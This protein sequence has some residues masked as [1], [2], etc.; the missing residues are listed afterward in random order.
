MEMKEKI[1]VVLP[2][3]NERD[4]IEPL[5]EAIHTSI[6]N[7]DHEI[8]VVD[9]N[10]PD[11]TY[12]LIAS[13][14]YPY[15][16]PILRTVNRGLA[17]SIRYGLEHAEG[18]IF[19]IMDSDF[20]H[21]PKYLPFMLQA[22]SYYDCVSASRFLYGGKMDSRLRHLLSWTFNIFVRLMTGGLI[23]DNLYG[24]LAIKRTALEQCNFNDIFWGYGDYCIRLLYYLQ[25]RETSILQIPAVNGRRRQGEGNSRFFQVFWQYFKEVLKLAYKVRIRENAQRDS[26]LSNMR[27]R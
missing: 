10:S 2:T 6:S 7:F 23:T 1:S 18:N 3:Y 14:E 25:K 17:S 12:Q 9:D 20:N 15:V 22:L 26:E 24:F 5:I 19:V 16:K 13:L 11:G 4:N 8:L 21:Q 27:K